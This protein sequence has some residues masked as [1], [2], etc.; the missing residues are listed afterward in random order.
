MSHFNLV[1]ENL[2]VVN[3]DLI[4]SSTFSNTVDFRKI[5]KVRDSNGARLGG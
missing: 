5:C 4:K 1:Q 3:H 2:K